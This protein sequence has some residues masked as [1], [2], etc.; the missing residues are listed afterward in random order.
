M[1]DNPFAEPDDDDSTRIMPRPQL[2]PSPPPQPPPP[3]TPPARSHPTVPPPAGF[4]DLPVAAAHPVVAAASPL[5]SLLAR[6]DN[7]A[8]VPDPAALRA[9]T[10]LE[11]RGYEQ[12]LRDARVSAE[13][14]R[15]SHYA[16]CASLDDV[17]Q[18]TPWGSHG[19]WADASLVST[20]HGEVRSGERFFDLLTRLCGSANKFLPVIELM[21]LCMS[22]GMRGRT[23]LSP[24]GPA[25]LDRIRE[26]TYLV[27]LRARGAAER[28]LSPNWKG[29]A[30]PYRPM[31]FRLPVWLAALC[32]MGALGLLYALV[33][34]NLNADSDR[35]FA[36]VLVLPAA[37]P[38]IARETTVVPPP[39][40]NGLREVLA[41]RLAGDVRDGMI[42]IAGTETAPIIRLPSG[43]A[44]ASGSAT[45]QPRSR[46]VLRRVADALQGGA[47]QAG[48]RAVRV[49]GYTDAQPIHTVAFPSNYQ[50]SVARARAAGAVLADAL[51]AGRVA[52]EGRADADP[53]GPNTTAAGRQQN[54]RIDI[55]VEEQNAP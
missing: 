18:N 27:I 21:Y 2:P 29:M 50:L 31:R 37:M 33:L 24:R 20:F 39:Q 35:F 10:M 41:S 46:A 26:E 3:P 19:P 54:R 11:V 51:G 17:V 53:L 44:F 12:A 48:G 52:E 47:P 23:R 30:A 7:V 40:P 32:A 14:I 34:L 28:A 4:G 1:N 6:L 13:Q 15:A 42:G 5:L 9:C 16:L 43:V 55:L 36:A 45:L 25:E 38:T 49:I 22:L 8:S